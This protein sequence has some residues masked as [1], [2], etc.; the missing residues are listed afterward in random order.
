MNRGCTVIALPTMTLSKKE[1]VQRGLEYLVKE[2][3]FGV[4]SNI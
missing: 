1:S 3:A 2:K 4:N